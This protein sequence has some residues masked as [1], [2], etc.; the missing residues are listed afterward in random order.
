MYKASTHMHT[1]HTRMHV[2]NQEHLVHPHAE[3]NLGRDDAV[4]TN[5]QTHIVLECMWI[6]HNRTPHTTH[7]KHMMTQHNATS[8]DTT[9]NDT[10]QHVALHYH[11]L[12]QANPS[13]W[14][15]KYCTIE[16]QW[17]SI[18]RARTIQ[19]R[20]QARDAPHTAGPARGQAQPG[21]DRGGL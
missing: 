8:H 16:Q 13:A 9:C 17:G 6:S 3:N 4:Q 19:Q 14:N 20:V 10:T 2:N 7:H 12:D 5:M 15:E 11:E 1:Q 18:N 21:N